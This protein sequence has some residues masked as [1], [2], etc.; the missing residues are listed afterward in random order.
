MAMATTSA[1]RPG[2]V[3]T[4]WSWTAMTVPASTGETEAASVAG[5]AANH[6]MRAGVGFRSAPLRPL[7]APPPASRGG[8]SGA[9]GGAGEVGFPLLDVGVTE[10]GRAHV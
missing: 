2:S 4:C 10:I 1:P 9:L 6:H 5:R 7:G 8:E 3:R